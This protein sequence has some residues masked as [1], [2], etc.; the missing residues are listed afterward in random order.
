MSDK[1]T[2]NPVTPSAEMLE[3][4]K[5]WAAP[6]VTEVKK[7]EVRDKTN[8]LGVPIEEMYSR[9]EQEEEEEEEEVPQL[10]PEEIEQIR[11]DAYNE[12]FELGKKEGFEQGQ[13]EGFEQ[14]KQEG[15][16]AGHEEGHAA[17]LEQGQQE[18]TQLS[19]RWQQLL[20]QLYNPIER[21]DEAAEKQLL[22]LAVMLAESVI[23]HETKSN[24]EALLSVLHESIASLPFNTE[25]AE[26]HMHPADIE[27]L[28]QVYNEE[29]IAER[30]WIIKPEPGYQMGDLVVATPNSLI[31]RTVKQRIKQTIEPFVQAAL[32]TSGSTPDDVE[33]TD[34]NLT[35]PEATEE[36][37]SAPEP[38][39][40]NPEQQQLSDE[41]SE[42]P[43]A[44]DVDGDGDEPEVSHD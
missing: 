24:K 28:E 8:F 21:V 13:Q 27:L 11:Q 36:T 40:S 16:T 30:K 1:L 31:D 33:S 12:G 23:R 10:T 39:V 7:A 20:D 43:E 26:L 18:I 5:S 35:S 2:K 38:Q 17:G 15:L 6:D 44:D 34:V 3:L 41:Q 4:L 42:V 9:L 19:A 22:N 14:G 37:V 29:A 32:D 25:Y